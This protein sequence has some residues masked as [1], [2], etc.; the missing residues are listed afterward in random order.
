MG[1]IV[2][3]SGTRAT[4]ANWMLPNINLCDGPSGFAEV[5]GGMYTC[6]DSTVIVWL[7]KCHEKE[8][9]AEFKSVGTRRSHNV[10]GVFH[11]RKACIPQ[12]EG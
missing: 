10:V 2:F 1:H 9:G 6:I 5:E 12:L 7:P 11:K 4:V 8:M 3:G